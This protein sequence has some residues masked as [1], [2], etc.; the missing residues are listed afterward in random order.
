MFSRVLVP[1]DGSP[2]AEQVLPYVRIVAKAG[3]SRIQLLR[4]VR[5]AGEDL[6]DPA[7]S[8]FPHQ[9][10]AN[11]RD[12]ALD[13]LREVGA[14]LTG[15]GVSTSY[16]VHLGDPASR[17]I[18]EADR[19]PGTLVAMSTHGRSGLARW[20]LGSVTTKV[21]HASNS[22]LFI[23]RPKATQV[24]TGEVRLKTVI[25]PLDGSDLAEQVLPQVA[26]LARP[27]ALDVKLLRVNPSVEE[28][29]VYFERHPVGSGATVYSGPYGE[30]SREADARA[31]EYLHEVRQKLHRRGV[32]SV[33]ETL[34]RGRP[35]E[36][37]VDMAQETPGSL[38]AM[39]THGRSG[40][41]RWLLGRVADRVIRGSGAPVL[42]VRGQE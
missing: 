39:T 15:L 29:Q 35:A 22:P 8:H 5:P 7:R 17:I 24:P 14:S 42:V 3:V 41:G 11:L 4:A 25:I 40:I 33:E 20:A 31:M 19:E 32:W 38:V 27:L 26:G 16:D 13:Y 36:A 18:T 37:I 12:Q 10:D 21:L 23:V 6:A 34:L 30:F 28:H 2:L 1:L 9:V